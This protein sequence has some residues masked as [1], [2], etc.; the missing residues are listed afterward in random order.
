MHAEIFIDGISWCLQVTS[1]DSGKYIHKTLCGSGNEIETPMRFLFCRFEK[2]NLAVS[3]YPTNILLGQIK[4]FEWFLVCRLYQIKPS[5]IELEVLPLGALGHIAKLAS[6]TIGVEIRTHFNKYE[7]K[8]EKLTKVEKIPSIDFL[9][10][11]KRL[12]AQNSK[13]LEY[14]PRERMTGKNYLTLVPVFLCLFF[15]LEISGVLPMVNFSVYS[16]SSIIT[17]NYPLLSVKNC[18]ENALIKYVAKC[19]IINPLQ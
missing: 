5:G 17:K 18:C 11:G 4:L 2:L 15:L 12:Q 1:N 16:F 13:A 19:F 8:E 10:I 6:L 9:W 7:T 3:Q 14:I